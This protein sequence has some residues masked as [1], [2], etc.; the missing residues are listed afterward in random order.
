MGKLLDSGCRLGTTRAQAVN[1][2]QHLRNSKAELMLYV[3]GGLKAIPQNFTFI[4]TKNIPP[5]KA[6]SR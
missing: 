6:H 1:F 2:E 5:I 3:S 4:F